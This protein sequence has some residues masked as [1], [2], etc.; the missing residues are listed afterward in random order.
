MGVG[1]LRQHAER[2][3]GSMMAPN[4]RYRCLLVQS[5]DASVLKSL[6]HEVAE[7]LKERGD[8]PVMKSA[9]AFFDA[10]SAL[11]CSEVIDF[12]EGSSSS[13]IIISGPLTFLDYWSQSMR[14][15]FWEYLATFT[16][17]PG[18]IL[19]DALRDHD[20]EDTFRVL[21]KLQGPDIR[22]LKSRLAAT[23]DGLV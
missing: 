7:I 1:P 20:F 10:T 2:L 14:R 21:G 13:S 9:S 8:Q 16:R 22:F 3:I 11:A 4:L 6:G 5:T 19:F 18:I 17:G 12:F 15:S 23:Q